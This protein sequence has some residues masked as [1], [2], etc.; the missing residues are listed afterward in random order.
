MTPA[1][2]TTRPWGRR[3]FILIAPADR[4]KFK[5]THTTFLKYRGRSKKL[6]KR[7]KIFTDIYVQPGRYYMI[8]EGRYVVCYIFVDIVLDETLEKSA[9]R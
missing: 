1:L 6:K 5:K 2:I 7:F 9:T 8:F 3:S 4:D